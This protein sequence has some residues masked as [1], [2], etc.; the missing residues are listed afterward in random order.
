MERLKAWLCI[1]LMLSPFAFP[2]IVKAEGETE[3]ATTGTSKTLNEVFSDVSGSISQGYLP[4]GFD[5][6]EFADNLGGMV[7]NLT[8]AYS[9][10]LYDVAHGNVAQAIQE[11]QDW[12]SST[13][14]NDGGTYTFDVESTILNGLIEEALESVVT[15]NGDCILFKPNATLADVYFVP[16]YTPSGVQ[17]GTI[18]EPSWAAASCPVFSWG[19]GTYYNET[20][21]MSLLNVS[22]LYYTNYGSFYGI[23]DSVTRDYDGYTLTCWA[24]YGGP[25]K[26]AGVP[27]IAWSTAQLAQSMSSRVNMAYRDAMGYGTN[28]SFTYDGVT[29]DWS[30]VNVQN[31]NIVYEGYT[32]GTITSISD[33]QGVLNVQLDGIEELLGQLAEQQLELIDYVRKIYQ[34]LQEREVP[35][36]EQ[37]EDFYSPLINWG[38][39]AQMGVYSIGDAV[40]SESVPVSGEFMTEF[41][42]VKVVRWLVLIPLIVAIVLFLIVWR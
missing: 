34:L 24:R 19:T 21:N 30:A 17:A 14:S 22:A 11:I 6:V 2:M 5:L 33:L 41:F 12:G 18:P 13:V 15:E 20:T 32:G 29:R 10:A 3:T 27:F 16:Y 40:E 28:I 9:S 35:F 7:V 39:L 31:H 42:N 4:G 36:S 23:Q 26:C 37:E 8:G 25:N 38:E 1:S